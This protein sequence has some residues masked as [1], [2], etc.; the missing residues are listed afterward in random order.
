MI[1]LKPGLQAIGSQLRVHL[2]QLYKTTNN[3]NKTIYHCKQQ[4]TVRSKTLAAIF[5][6]CY[7]ATNL[8]PCMF[9]TT[10]V[11]QSINNIAH[12]YCFAYLYLLSEIFHLKSIILI[13]Q[14]DYSALQ[15]IFFF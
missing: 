1:P 14:L 5:V 7:L 10:R 4:H 12:L 11:Y 15:I 13:Q 9:L 8:S 3:N 2:N 6:T